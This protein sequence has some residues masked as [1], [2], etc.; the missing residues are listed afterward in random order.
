MPMKVPSKLFLAGSVLLLAVASSQADTILY[1]QAFTGGSASALNG[2]AV[3]GG[4]L[5]GNWIA[6]TGF[7][8]DGV[9]T[10]DR[11]SAVLSFTPVQGNVYQLSS[12]ITVSS[13]LSS[14]LGLGFADNI[15]FTGQSG[16]NADRFAG[17]T[18]IAGYAWMFTTSAS[19]TTPNQAYFQGAGVG[20]PV[21][22]LA[23][24]NFSLTSFHIMIEL[25]ASGADWATK[26]YLN[27]TLVG[28][29]NYAGTAPI[30]SVG[31]TAGTS[32]AGTFSNFQLVQV[33]P[34]PSTVAMLGLG[35]GGLTCL[36]RFRRR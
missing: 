7:Q 19:A 21:T 15:S 9:A 1:S 31:F 3:T 13:G 5:T 25:D 18:I 26:Y 17:T 20:G 24:D 35:F 14:F 6:G 23:P 11:T 34:E 4:T 2:S 33:V 32:S 36:H 28:S 29:T 27:N 16:A 8:Q 12:D 10:V 22:E 30:D